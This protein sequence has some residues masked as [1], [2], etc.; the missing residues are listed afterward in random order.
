MPCVRKCQR[1]CV[2][3]HSKEHRFSRIQHVHVGLS[4]VSQQTMLCSWHPQTPLWW[5]QHPR[6][7]SSGTSGDADAANARVVVSA[8]PKAIMVARIVMR[9]PPPLARETPAL[10][11][12][13]GFAERKSRSLQ[14]GPRRGVTASASLAVVKVD[15]TSGTPESSPHI[16]ATICRTTACSACDGRAA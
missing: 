9:P 2:P 13:L 3:I 12:T 1:S 10:K 5:E 7:S 11:I 4:D 16:T 15:V 14:C 8:S 6:A